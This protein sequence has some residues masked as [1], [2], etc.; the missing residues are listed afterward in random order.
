MIGRGS[1]AVRYCWGS[2]N[3]MAPVTT[4]IRASCVISAIFI[5]TNEL[6]FYIQRVICSTFSLLRYSL[7]MKEKNIN[8]SGHSGHRYI[9]VNVNRDGIS[10]NRLLIQYDDIVISDHH[11]KRP[12]Y[13]GVIKTPGIGKSPGVVLQ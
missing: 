6:G 4:Y 9:T 13:S 5:P 8:I 2:A 12:M 10:W 11:N 1:S 7:K 3:N